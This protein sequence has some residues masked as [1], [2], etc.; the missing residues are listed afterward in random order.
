MK[1]HLNQEEIQKALTEYINNQGINL[2]GKAVD[3]TLTAG[4][5]SNGHYAEITISTPEVPDTEE[6]SDSEEEQQ[7][8]N[9][10][11]A[12]DE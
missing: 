6:D 10:E 11:F 7:A 2:T 8:I 5:G 1:I 3:V 4:R 9:F 12:E